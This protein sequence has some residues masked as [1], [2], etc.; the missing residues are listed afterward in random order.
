MRFPTLTLLALASAS[1]ASH[2][3]GMENLPDGAYSGTN[4]RDGSTTMTSLDS[5]STYTFNLVKPA[6]EQAKRSDN[7]LSKRLTSC[8]GYELDHGGTDD[9]VRELK[10]WAGTAG[11]DLASGNTRNYYGFNRK[12]VYVYY[13]INGLHTQGNLDI[14][15]IEY[16]MWAMDKGCGM[17]QAGYFLWPGSPE[18]V[19]RC[20]SSTAICLG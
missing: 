10:D 5:G 2:W 14:K 7:A 4:H 17:Y 3:A 20:R 6:T 15:D 1:A 11:V 18:I 13:C 19:G 9:G 8:W 16:A 12:G